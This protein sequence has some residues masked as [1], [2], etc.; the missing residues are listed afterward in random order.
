MRALLW[1]AVVAFTASSFTSALGQEWDWQ[2]VE[3]GA[4]KTPTLLFTPDPKNEA[5]SFLPLPLFMCG[6]EHLTIEIQLQENNL[7][8]I[9][10]LLSEDKYP[11]AQLNEMN[12]IVSLS[13]IYYSDV[14]GWVIQFF[15]SKNDVMKLLRSK[16][17]VISW[18]DWVYNFHVAPNISVFGEFEERCSKFSKTHRQSPRG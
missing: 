4:T 9:A 7:N 8:K 11:H 10:R 3:L 18:Y 2:V 14:D 16:K 6:P 17:F 13:K 15:A 5:T 1:S 12:K